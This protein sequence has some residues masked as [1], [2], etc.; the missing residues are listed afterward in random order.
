MTD[1]LKEFILSSQKSLI[2]LAQKYLKQ[3]TEA[4][5]YCGKKL[6]TYLPGLNNSVS[7][8]E[9]SLVISTF[10]LF[11]VIVVPILMHFKAKHRRKK[12]LEIQID[13]IEIQPKPHVTFTETIST[14]I[15]HSKTVPDSLQNSKNGTPEKLPDNSSN[16]NLNG[17]VDDTPLKSPSTDLVSFIRKM[18]NTGFK[19]IR[20]KKKLTKPQVLR[21]DSKGSVVWSR[22]FFMK[23]QPITAL[24]SAFESDSG[25]ILEFKKKTLHF[26]VDPSE[27]PQYDAGTMIR[28]FTAIIKRLK[29][30]PSYVND[31]CK[32]LG[33]QND[34]FD[35]GASEESDTTRSSVSSMTKPSTG[36]TPVSRIS[37]SS[38]NLPTVAEESH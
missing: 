35:D 14:N 25:F 17:S 24:M 11:L 31:I 3:Y 38:S 36:I 32:D 20:I 10:T 37:H 30:E 4:E 7:K 34:N 19:V 28:Y 12:T 8:P 22:S 2:D 16:E 29:V 5:I 23:S 18:R 9:V 26:K 21:L 33:S 27:L 1:N 13:N 15:N 6:A